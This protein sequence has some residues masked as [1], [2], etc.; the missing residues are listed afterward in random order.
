MAQ[1]KFDRPPL[2][3]FLQS[4]ISLHLQFLHLFL[5]PFEGG[6]GELLKWIWPHYAMSF[7]SVKASIGSSRHADA[8][9]NDGWTS[10]VPRNSSLCATVCACPIAH[11]SMRDEALFFAKQ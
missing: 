9:N 4:R 2:A 8:T 3:T 5:N 1:R 10:E 6:H 7:G 11:A